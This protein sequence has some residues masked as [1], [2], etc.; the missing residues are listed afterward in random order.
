MKISVKQY[1]LALFEAS[2][3]KNTKDLDM[4]LDN[5]I[6]EIISAGLSGK[7]TLILEKFKEIWNEK[8][9]EIEADLITARKL[10]KA[11]EKYIRE[12]ILEKTK[13]KNIKLNQKI[14]KNIIGGVILKYNGKVLDLSFY[15]R[16]QQFKKELNKE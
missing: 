7:L 13:A 4:V 1:A 14:D 15:N 11:E 3:G 2:E 8:N 12:T 6:R 5:F 10:E 16:I 9:S